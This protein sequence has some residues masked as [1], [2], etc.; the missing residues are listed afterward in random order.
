MGG[1]LQGQQLLGPAGPAEYGGGK[2]QAELDGKREEADQV[3]TELVAKGAEISEQKQ[4]L[5]EE[6]ENLLSQIAQKEKEYNNA[7]HQEWLAYMATYTT[8]PP[9]TTAASGTGVNG[10][11]NNGSSI[12]SSGGNWLRPCS[13]TYM[14]SPFGFRQSPVWSPPRLTR[15]PQDTM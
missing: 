12:P 5:E 2:T 9:A 15:I 7:K 1:P 4:L 11:S 14:S 13:Y 3:I 6:D 8:V 10:S